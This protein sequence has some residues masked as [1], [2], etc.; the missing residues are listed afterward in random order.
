MHAR[1]DVSRSRGPGRIAP[2]VAL[3]ALLAGT[4]PPALAQLV[5]FDPADFPL[6]PTSPVADGYGAEAGVT[7]TY[8]TLATFG[9]AAP[10]GSGMRWWDGGHGALTGVA[11]GYNQVGSV[12]EVGLRSLVPGG[13]VTLTDFQIASWANRDRMLFVQ[14]LGWDHSLVYEITVPIGPNGLSFLSFADFLS[15]LGHRAPTDPEGFRIQWTQDASPG[16][17]DVTGR[18]AYDAGI[19]NV[20]FV[21]PGVSTVPEPATLALLGLG[22]A[23]L[24][25]VARA[26]R[27]R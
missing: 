26:R 7:T 23:G 14:L 16:T 15:Q 19:D 11:Y 8:R 20:A 25:G 21:G 1:P 6:G 4:A 10:V 18:G 27:P 12:A 2:L 9:D 5:T 17:P 24:A 3:V 22:L 13:P